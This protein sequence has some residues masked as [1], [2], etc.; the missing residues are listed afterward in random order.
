MNNQDILVI[1]GT[2][3]LLST[4]GKCS[5]DNRLKEAVWSR[6]R[7]Q[8]IADKLRALGCN[9]MIDYENN[10]LPVS[11]RTKNPTLAQRREL[12]I[13]ANNI[14]K[15]C[16]HYRSIFV[17]I[18]VNAAGADGKWHNAGGWS[19]YTSVGKTKADALAECLYN[20]AEKYLDGYKFDMERGKERGVYSQNQRAFRTDTSDGDRDL[21]ARF[22]ILDKTNCPAVLT[23]NLFQDNPMDVDF[24]L[25]PEGIEAIEQLHVEGILNY[26][27]SL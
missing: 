4:P 10:L 5:P 21:E 23:E 12:K 27:A 7:V 13:R 8:S 19:A 26:I 22:Y 14:N 17:S 24:L 15:L 2:A 18:H 1:L 16:K 11:Q 20:A 9:V 25:S 6:E 3:H